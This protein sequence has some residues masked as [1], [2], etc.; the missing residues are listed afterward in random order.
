MALKFRELCVQRI[1]CLEE[2]VLCKLVKLVLQ[3]CNS[4]LTEDIREGIVNQV[5]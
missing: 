4:G 1:S 3:I 5:L 2:G